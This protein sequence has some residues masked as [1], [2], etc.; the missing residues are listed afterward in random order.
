MEYLDADERDLIESVENGEWIPVEDVEA[1]KKRARQRA[2]TTLRR[3][4]KCS[5]GTARSSRLR[6]K[7]QERNALKSL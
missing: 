5:R 7:F 6:P 4:G 1:V 3:D 2:M